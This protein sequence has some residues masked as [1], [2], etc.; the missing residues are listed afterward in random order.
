MQ[1]EKIA[2][3]TRELED[4]LMIEEKR[5]TLQEKKGSVADLLAEME[6]AVASVEA[7]RG[8]NEKLPE[9]MEHLQGV[10]TAE[11]P[12]KIEPLE[13]AGMPEDAEMPKRAGIPKNAEVTKKAGMPERAETWEC[14]KRNEVKSEAPKTEAAEPKTVKSV[15]KEPRKRFT[16]P[17]KRAKNACANRPWKSRT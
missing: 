8:Q 17:E 5:G 13:K 12:E 11:A 14:A 7:K 4:L 15:R 2:C 6:S 16:R 1:S 3:V 10:E 9:K